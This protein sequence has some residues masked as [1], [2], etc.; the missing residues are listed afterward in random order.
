MAY[1]QQPYVQQQQ[2]VYPSAP[3]PPQQYA[4]PTYP[5]LPQPQAYGAPPPQV[6][7]PQAQ[8]MPQYQGM[9]PAQAMAPA[10]AGPQ[11]PSGYSIMDAFRNG[12]ELQLIARS[13]GYPLTIRNKSLFGNG[14][15]V[16]AESRF[17]VVE[18]DKAGRGVIMLQ[19]MEW[20]GLHI[21]IKSHKV[22]VTS[23]SDH[24]HLRPVVLPDNYVVFESVK[25]PGE[26]VAMQKNDVPPEKVNGLSD[27]D[28]MVQFFVRVERQ[29]HTY[30]NA[31]MTPFGRPSIANQLRDQ[32][33][34]Q[35]YLKSSNT[36]L[37]I[38][39]NG[40]VLST[41]NGGD[42]HT[43]F[44]WVDRGMGIVSL[45][46]NQYPGYRLRMNNFVL[47]GKGDP[48]LLADWRLKENPDG[49]VQFESVTCQGACVGIN[50]GGALIR[51][52]SIF[53]VNIQKF[54]GAETITK[55]PIN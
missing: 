38:N 1:Q 44:K 29:K 8:G 9:P 52:L 55:S 21:A 17:K 2:G 13:T 12:N 48:T 28:T 18:P 26:Y 15:F 4:P 24:C 3:P 10:P 30:S 33:V 53:L 34:I 36:F 16:K 23:A 43:F 40:I 45:H 37:S 11:M 14:G 41:A 46:S 6:M 39:G 51:D 50:Q 20:A 42:K 54:G 31:I 25:S 35:L 32:C 7:A 49:T 47:E 22:Q 27:G 19:N 5:Q